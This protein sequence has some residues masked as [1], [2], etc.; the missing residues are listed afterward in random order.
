V[1][2]FIH[3]ANGRVSAEDGIQ[4]HFLQHHASVFK[5]SAWHKFKPLDQR[6]SLLAAVRFHE[7]HNNI[8]ALALEPVGFLQHFK[9]LANSSGKTKVDFQTPPLL[10]LNQSKKLFRIGPV[11]G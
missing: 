3:Q 4:V 5:F 2:Q 1:S 11:F 10:P 9:G 6:S 7:A 8:H